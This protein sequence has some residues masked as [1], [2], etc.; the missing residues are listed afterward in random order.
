ML[1]IKSLLR[2]I[3]HIKGIIEVQQLHGRDSFGAFETL[4][5][6]E[7]MEEALRINSASLERHDIR[8]TRC[9]EDVEPLLM[10]RHKVLQILVNLVRNARQATAANPPANRHLTVSIQSVGGDVSIRVSD[11]G[12]GIEPGNLTRIFSHGFTTKK[13]GHGFGLHSGALAASQ[14]GG[15][16]EVHSDGPGK[17]AT[18]TLVLKRQAG[19]ESEATAA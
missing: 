18:F 15:S 17:G 16:L 11:N 2:N 14:M 19:E 4:P 9:Y 10:E 12:V 5:P 1:E 3:D 13:D 7:I 8:V 6:V